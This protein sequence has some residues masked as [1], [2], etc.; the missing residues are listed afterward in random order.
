[1]GAGLGG[2]GFGQA[3]RVFGGRG[4][5]GVWR[6]GWRGGGDV[7]VRSGNV[8]TTRIWT[9]PMRTIRSKERARGKKKWRKRDPTDPT[10]RKSD[11]I[12]EE[13]NFVGEKRIFCKSLDPAPGQA[14]DPP[15]KEAHATGPY[16]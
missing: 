13:V 7:E 6:A 5:G 3:G 1:M 10:W 12:G 9:D 8:R 4:G 16:L 2:G 11:E 14:V 15:V